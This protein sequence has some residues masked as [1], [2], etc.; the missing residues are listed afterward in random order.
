LTGRTI[1]SSEIHVISSLSVSKNEK[2]K[3]MEATKYAAISA[4]PTYDLSAAFARGTG[5]PFAVFT[6]ATKCT[7]TK[8][9]VAI[10]NGT[11]RSPER[12]G[13]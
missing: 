13:R 8:T 12:I 10:A 7:W 11:K 9:K 6:L 1:L 3:I 5:N 4:L 2:L